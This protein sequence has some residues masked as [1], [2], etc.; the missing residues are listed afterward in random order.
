MAGSKALMSAIVTPTP[1]AATRS[2]ARLRPIARWDGVG[3]SDGR[4]TTYLEQPCW[5]AR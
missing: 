2:S 4:N 1:I 3:W 5:P